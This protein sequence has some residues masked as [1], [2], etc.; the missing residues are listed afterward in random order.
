MFGLFAFVLSSLL[1]IT[2]AV[3]QKAA[4]TTA[5]KAAP[6]GTVLNDG[7]IVYKAPSFD[8]PVLG[9]LRAGKTYSISSRLFSGAFYKILV[10]KGVMGYIADTD[11][12][13]DQK[14]VKAMKEERAKAEK[15]Y[16][17]EADSLKRKPFDQ[18]QFGGLGYRLLQYRESVLGG[19]K[20]GSVPLIGMSIFGPA[21]MGIDSQLN[22]L[23]SGGAPEYYKT[24]TGNST[25][26]F[27]LIADLLLETVF[28]QSPSVV[29]HFGFGPM[30]RHHKYNLQI[31]STPKIAQGTSLGAV[32]SLGGAIRIGKAAVRGEVIYHHELSQYLGYQASIEYGF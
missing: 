2:P 18:M 28:P 30:L 19:M 10:K 12:S 26:G 9:Y 27:L 31:G 11:I 32:F 5:Q 17:M 20:K 8:A 16:E 22:I 3:A 24:Q 6:K 13:T 25:S 23:M 14:T 1:A 21:L 15:Q 29:T 7:A 4:P